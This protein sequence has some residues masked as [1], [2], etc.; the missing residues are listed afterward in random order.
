MRLQQRANPADQKTITTVNRWPLIVKHAAKI[1][2]AQY[3]CRTF[4]SIIYPADKNNF[5]GISSILAWGKSRVGL[6]PPFIAIHQKSIML[7]HRPQGTSTR[8]WFYYIITKIHPPFQNTRSAPA[9]SVY[10]FIY[11]HFIN[12]LL[13]IYNTAQCKL[14]AGSLYG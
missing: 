2:F 12:L 13:L 7:K 10:L 8:L 1:T 9:W 14:E 11:L 4:Q 3:K 6:P 5:T